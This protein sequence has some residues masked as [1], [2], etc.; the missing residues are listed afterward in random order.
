MINLGLSSA[1]LKLYQ[2]SLWSGY[3]LKITVQILDLNHTYISDV[4]D[5]LL[6]GQVNKSFEDNV[7]SNA[8]LELLDPDNQVGFDSAN[9]SEGAIYADRMVKIIYSVFS[10]LLPKWVDCPIFCGP[11]IKVSRDDA[12][13]SIECQGKES[14]YLEPEMAWTAKTYAKGTA[15]VTT[16]RDLLGNKGGETKFDLPGWTRTIKQDYSLTVETPIW[17]LAQ[18]L[19]GSRLAQQL[20]Y[21]GRGY[22]KLRATPTTPIFTFT[23]DNMTSVP[24]LAFESDSIRNT[25][26]VKGG[27]PTGKPQIIGNSELAAGDPSSSTALGRKLANGT[28]VKRRLVEIVEDST[29]MTQTAADQLAKSTLASLDLQNVT[30]DFDSFVIPHLEQGDVFSI[31][32]RDFGRDLRATQFSIPLRAGP[33]SNGTNRQLVPTSRRNRKR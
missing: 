3:N 23:P 26:R 24:K 12:I 5:R 6:G 29:I 9:P 31:S 7:S 11:V 4:S 15:L 14:L 28:I 21:D 33:Q 2:Q 1:E 10:D 13:V 30:F 18:S 20:F 16:V 19:V 17:D 27:T 22:L 25:V 32:T 8:T